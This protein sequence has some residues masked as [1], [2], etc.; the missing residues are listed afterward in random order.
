MGNY[1][2]NFQVFQDVKES[3]TN[4][5]YFSSEIL[6]TGESRHKENS[7]VS[8]ARTDSLFIL[9]ESHKTK[10]NQYVSFP[11]CPTF[12]VSFTSEQPVVGLSPGVSVLARQNAH[13]FFVG[14]PGLRP[15]PQQ[16]AVDLTLGHPRA[17]AV[18]NLQLEKLRDTTARPL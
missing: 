16:L 1:S 8:I 11:R 12:L 6:M 14:F 13:W 3:C 9:S 17:V 15:D 5:A 2:L 18:V 4:C 10:T 7:P